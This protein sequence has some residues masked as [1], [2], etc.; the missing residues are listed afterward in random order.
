[1]IMEAC[2]VLG[3]EDR[4]FRDCDLD[5]L[6]AAF[7]KKVTLNSRK[8]KRSSQKISNIPVKGPSTHVIARCYFVASGLEMQK[9]LQCFFP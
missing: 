5:S 9:T 8:G 1:M 6:S 3:I 2:G 4:H 7:T